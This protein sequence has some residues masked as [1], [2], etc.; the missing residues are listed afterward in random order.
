VESLTAPSPALQ[1]DRIRKDPR[2][3]HLLVTKQWSDFHNQGQIF[4]FSHSPNENKMSDDGR[5]CA[6]LAVKVWKSSQK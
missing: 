1:R 5:V 2:F 3:Q 6:P 4:A